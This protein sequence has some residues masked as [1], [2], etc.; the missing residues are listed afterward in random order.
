LAQARLSNALTQNSVIP[1]AAQ[2]RSGL[3]RL[4]AEANIGEADGPKGERHGWR[5]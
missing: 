3:R 5:E 4:E 1:D 2:R